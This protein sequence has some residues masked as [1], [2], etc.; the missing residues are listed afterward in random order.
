MSRPPL[1]VV[2]A[3]EV[4]TCAGFSHRPP[5][6]DEQASVGELAGAA[7]AMQDGRFV[8]IGPED[9]LR[10]SFRPAG[11]RVIDAAGGVV[12]PG[13]VDAHTHTIFAG[14]R[15]AEWERR[16]QGTS[17]LD[18]LK[19]G[20]GIRSTVRA[21]RVAAEA[22]L[23]AHA[24]RWARRA[25]ELGTTT[26]ETKSGY[27]LDRETEL[28]LL[29]VATALRDE[30]PQKIVRTFLGAHVVPE[31]HRGRR[32]D[33][34]DL[35][36]ALT[37]EVA[38]LGLAEFAD[39][40]C[41]QEAFTLAECERLCRT[42]MAAGLGV[43]VHAE[44]FGSSGAARL[45]ADLGAVSIDHLEHLSDDDLDHL[46][47]RARPPV[48]VLLPGVPFHLALADRAPARALVRA[49]VPVALATD[50]NPGS[51][52]TPSLP[53]IIG[54]ACRTLSLGV[55]EAIVATT[56]S[57]AHAVGL[58]AEVGS[59]E[60]GKRADLVVLDV[61]DRRWLGYAFGW[62]PVKTVVADGRCVAGQ[63]CD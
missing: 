17:Y 36:D 4:V 25:L 12:A 3:R 51:S 27:G 58:G 13:F 46:A 7:V 23:L 57:A 16:M 8:A 41:E 54:L 24:R 50:F 55:D 56:I 18:L 28:R 37:R 31:E 20:G 14:D 26:L 34:V 32:D 61:P 35:V 47:A 44:Q 49:G 60:V 2:G 43:K 63:G 6:G 40:F 53:M 30:V 52:F 5:R 48:A 42:A 19:E 9:E 1:L 11:L 59:L 15:A 45:A 22:E 38:A 10:A 39:V 21:T 62:N 29:R 33:Y